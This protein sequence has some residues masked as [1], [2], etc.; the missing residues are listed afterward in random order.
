MLQNRADIKK[1][2]FIVMWPGLNPADYRIDF[3]GRDLTSYIGVSDFSQAEAL[4]RELAAKGYDAYN[5]CGAFD[6]DKAARLAQIAGPG[7]PVSYVIFPGDEPRK[8]EHADITRGLGIIIFDE[9]IGQIHPFELKGAL[10]SHIRFVDSVVMA[11]A[12]AGDLIREGCSVLEL[13]S[14]FDE[15]RT[16]ALIHSLHCETPIGTAGIRTVTA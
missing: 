15:N 5:L 6:Q 7:I 13:C 8:R 12:A 2:A 10:N 1:Y 9:G 4:V 16:G 3:Q 11:R 14:W